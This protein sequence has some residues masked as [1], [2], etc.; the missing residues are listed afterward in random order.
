MF[1]MFHMKIS[2]VLFCM[3]LVSAPSQGEALEDIEIY[4]APY[5]MA[6]QP[7]NRGLS[8]KGRGVS[9]ERIHSDPGLGVKIGLFPSFFHGYLGMELESFGHHNSLSFPVAEGG[10]ATTKGK[11]SLVTY[12]SMINLQLRYPGRYV[13]PY[14]GIGGGLSN[15]I[16]RH[17]DI[18][19]RK[20]QN[21]EMS[22]APSY[23]LFGGVQLVIAK[24]WFVFGEYKYSAANYHWKQ[25]SLNF[26]SEYF[27]GGVGYLF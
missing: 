14:L 23:Q 7:S 3:M 17:P 27:L 15:G 1:Q 11:S 24:R 2:L 4:L 10:M 6:T 20:D 18:P 19:A 12:S 5:G 16:L 22:S 21:I 13:R 8:L 26:R 25:L 9:D